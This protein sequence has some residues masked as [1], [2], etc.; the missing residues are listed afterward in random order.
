MRYDYRTNPLCTVKKFILP[1]GKGFY[2]EGRIRGI[3]EDGFDHVNWF[4][5]KVY[6]PENEHRKHA[7]E[8]TFM[9]A[10]GLEFYRR[11]LHSRDKERRDFAREEIRK[12]NLYEDLIRGASTLQE[13]EQKMREWCDSMGMDISQ[14]VAE[15]V[16]LRDY[17]LP[18]PENVN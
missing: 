7:R 8:I 12:I 1:Y 16:G 3:T 13:T 18:L 5:G 9:S 6:Y 17:F 10:P 2:L 4:A 15:T 11:L 14:V